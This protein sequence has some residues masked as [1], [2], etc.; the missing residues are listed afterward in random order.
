MCVLDIEKFHLGSVESAQ[1]TARTEVVSPYSAA[2]CVVGGEV[3]LDHLDAHPRPG[4]MILRTIRALQMIAKLSLLVT[5][6]I[7]DTIDS[8]IA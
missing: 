3:G 8:I 6:R 4:D 2:K 1:L 7:D 5:V